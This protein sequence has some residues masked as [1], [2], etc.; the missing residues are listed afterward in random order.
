MSVRHNISVLRISARLGFRQV[1]AE[2]LAVAG[3]FILLTVI[4]TSY[5]GLFRLLPPEKLA[6]HGMD[7]AAMVWYIATVEF[8]LFCAA[9]YWRDMETDI[10]SGQIGLQLSRPCSLWIVKTG[11]WS[12]QYVARLLLLIL[13]AMAMTA[14]VSGAPE[15]AWGFIAAIFTAFPLAALVY[16]CCQFMLGA[17]TMWIGHAGAAHMIW[18]KALFFLGAMLWPLAMYPEPLRQ[19]VWLTPF[20]SI[21]AAAGWWAAPHGMPGLAACVAIQLAWA[22]IAVA[23]AAIVN[24]RMM[25]RLMNGGG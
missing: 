11:E 1:F 3:H 21:L 19:L 7:A 13:P 12:G 17:S 18:Q 16:L 4:V 22:A 24:R 10:Q 2:K 8:V 25:R 14:W 15:R 9:Y 20:P 23:G 6:A 5:G